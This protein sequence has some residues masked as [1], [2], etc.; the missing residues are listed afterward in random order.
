MKIVLLILGVAV[1]CLAGCAS[2]PEQAVIPPLRPDDPG[3]RHDRCDYAHHELICHMMY[4]VPSFGPRDG[5][6]G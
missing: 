3:Y 2:F 4:G 5:G 1:L 6:G